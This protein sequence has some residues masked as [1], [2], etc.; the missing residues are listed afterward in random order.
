MLWVLIEAPQQGASNEYTQHMFLW[1]YKKNYPKM[2]TKY[3]SLTIPLQ[4][5]PHEKW[6]TLKW[7]QLLGGKF[8]PFSIDSF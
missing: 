5:V 4:Q 3:F 6:S 2:I 7:K 1:S 8:L